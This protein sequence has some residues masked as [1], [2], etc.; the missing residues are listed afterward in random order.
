MRENAR[1]V[2][3]GCFQTQTL[4]YEYI[5]LECVQG[6]ASRAPTGMPWVRWALGEGLG[7][8]LGVGLVSPTPLNLWHITGAAAGASCPK[9]LH[10]ALEATLWT[11][12]PSETT[13]QCADLLALES[14]TSL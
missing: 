7:Q 10:T 6:R 12:S 11:C 13:G 5:L 9:K 14:D 3:A 4:P 8:G 2:A 1:A